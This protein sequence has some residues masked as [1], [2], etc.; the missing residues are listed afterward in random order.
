MVEMEDKRQRIVPILGTG[1]FS[2]TCPKYF[3]DVVYCDKVNNKL[4]QFSSATHANNIIT[5]SRT[6]K[7]VE[8]ENSRGLIELFE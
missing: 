8:K 2:K 1:N 4:K 5:G 7:M 6:G 3:D